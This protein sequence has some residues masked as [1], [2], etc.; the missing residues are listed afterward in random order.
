MK[1]SPFDQEFL[2]EIFKFTTET[3]LRLNSRENGRLE[4]KEAWNFGNADAYAKTMAAFAN[5]TGGYLVF[6]VADSPRQLIGLKNDK[7]DNLDAAKFTQMLNSSLAP[8]IKWDAHVHEVRGKKVGLVYAHEAERK[9]VVCTKNTSVLQ[10]AAIY[11]RYRAQSEKIHYPE[12]RH[13]LDKQIEQIH[14][15]W[16][17]TLQRMARIGIENVGVLDSATGEVVGGRGSFLIPE[18]LLPQ[19]RF[20]HSG[21]FVEKGGDPALKLVGEVKSVSGGLL[22]PTRFV[23]K[24]IHGF[25][26][27]ADFV[28]QTSVLSPL[29]YVKQ[30]CFESSPYYPVYFFVSQTPSTISQVIAELEKVTSRGKIREELLRRLKG[31][32]V[33]T[34]GGIDGKTPSAIKRRDVYEKLV[35]KTLTDDEVKADLNNFF[36]ALTH[37]DRKSADREFI[38]GLLDRNVLPSYGNIT[39][40][41]GTYFRKAICHLDVIWFKDEVRKRTQ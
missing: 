8:E 18:D 1:Q 30:I 10:E 25:D 2:D 20:I 34:Q 36:L 38:L 6:G 37:L 15:L 27:I 12:L 35:A 14:A 28:H 33:F 23:P 4:F 16:I 40:I 31:N 13:L 39:G 29:D 17:G 26:I 11:Y 7:F 5:S 21:S 24:P 41:Q 19:L 32:E 22:Q 3:G 9:P